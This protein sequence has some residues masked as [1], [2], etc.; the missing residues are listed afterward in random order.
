VAPTDRVEASGAQNGYEVESFQFG[1]TLDNWLH[2]VHVVAAM[3]WVGGGLILSV[4]GLRARSSSHPAAVRE[5]GVVLPYVGIRV[6]M[7]AVILVLVTGVWMVIASAEWHFSQF[8]VI[9]AL[10]LFA[11]AFLIGAV[12]LSRVGIQMEQFANAQSDD[13][14]T[15]TRLLD[16]W[17]AGY[18][19]VLAVLL[20]AVWDMVFKP[21]T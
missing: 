6:L 21:G 9:F 10:G 17:L 15:G 4:M 7:P 11:V 12:Y 20:V 13:A 18:G 16:R 8:W 19:I 5:F 3:A 1:M 2:F 14:S